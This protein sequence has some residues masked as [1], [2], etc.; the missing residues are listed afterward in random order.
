MLALGVSETTLME[1]TAAYAALG[2][3]RVP[4]QPHGVQL[5]DAEAGADE[6]ADDSVVKDDERIALLQLLQAAVEEGTAR[7]ARLSKPTFGK[8]GTTQDNRDAL[9]IGLAGDLAV[10]VWVGNDDNAP[11]REVTGGGLPARM[12][13]QFT[14]PA[15]GAHAWQAAQVRR[16][17]PP[18]KSRWQSFRERV[19][20]HGGKEHGRGK[21]KGHGKGKGKGKK[22]H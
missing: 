7:A 2:A 5:P 15:I 17:A 13:A 22:H 1:L 12:W 3:K 14:A 18:A 8:T 19:F 16:Q 10:G 6:E 4:V 9:F 20:G 11:M 21:G